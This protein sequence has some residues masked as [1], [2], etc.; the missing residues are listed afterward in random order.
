MLKEYGG[1]FEQI[2]NVG[3][4]IKRGIN[5]FLFVDIKIIEFYL[6]KDLWFLILVE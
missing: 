6:G 5:F 1:Y 4:I 3:L 2:V